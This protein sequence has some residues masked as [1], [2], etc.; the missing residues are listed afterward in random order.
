MHLIVGQINRIVCRIVQLESQMGASGI[1][2]F[3]LPLD[4]LRPKEAAQFQCLL[5]FLTPS[6][7]EGLVQQE[8]EGKKNPSGPYV[9]PSWPNQPHLQNSVTSKTVT[10]WASC[11]TGRELFTAVSALCWS[12]LPE[13]SQSQPITL[14]C[15]AL[16]MFWVVETEKGSRGVEKGIEICSHRAHCPSWIYRPPSLWGRI[17]DVVSCW[18]VMRQH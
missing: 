1:C 11:S 6:V 13:R 14:L 16:G 3:V 15:A 7:M 2:W 4:E 12:Y 8:G 17:Y 9:C 10:V 18:F 5:L